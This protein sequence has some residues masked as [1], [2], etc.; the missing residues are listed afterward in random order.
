MIRKGEDADYF[1]MVNSGKFDVFL[2]EGTEGKAHRTYTAG[3][4]F[5]EL[6]LLYNAPRAA[7]VKCSEN[8]T[9]WVLDRKAFRY[10]MVRTGYRELM[11]KTDNFLKTC[12]LLSPLTDA[13]RTKLAALMEEVTLQ[14]GEYV[15]KMGDEAASLYFVKKG[16]VVCHKHDGKPRPEDLRLKTGAVF[17]ESCLEPGADDAVRKANVVA[18]GEVQLLKLS[19]A[20][21]KE[22]L[23]TLADVVARNFMAKVLESV[24]IDDTPIFAQL[25]PIELEAFM[26][27]LTERSYGDGENLIEEGTQQDT[28]FIVKSGHAHVYHDEDGAKKK[29]A[30]R[31]EGQFFGER[32]LLTSEPAAATITA[33]SEALRVYCCDRDAF[34]TAIGPVKDLIT[35]EAEKRQKALRRTKEAPQ[36]ADLEHRRIVGVGTYGRVRLCL[37][38]VTGETYALKMMRKHQVV[39]TKQQAHVISEKK[40]LATCDHPFIMRLHATYHDE[41]ELYMLLELVQG[42]E[43]YSMLK[44]Q[45]PLDETKVVF[46]V[47]QVTSIISYLHTLDI[48]YRDLKPENLLLDADGYLKLVDFGFAKVLTDRTWTL[49]GTPEYLAPE[50]ILVKGHGFGVDWW[51]VGILA[52]ECLTGKTPFATDDPI[53]LYRK[54]L[55][56]HIP[57]PKNMSANARDAINRLV[58]VDPAKRLGCLKA[59]SDEVRT[60]PF[61]ASIEWDKLEERAITPPYKPT[62][63]NELDDSNFH[64]HFD[65]EAA[66]FYP[67]S[68]FPKQMF[69]EFAQTWVGQP[70]A[71]RSKSDLGK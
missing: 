11:D 3:E 63:K 47:A 7:T 20:A 35:R 56:C 9:L 60:H 12:S 49:C 42:G 18:V 55:K 15:I 71:G 21:F 27:K 13:Q 66:K 8:G 52:F 31:V 6:A 57:W 51:T 45:A 44:R 39:V 33:A 34:T 59:G 68:N 58:R 10:V 41:G 62:I 43:L 64:S 14:D 1:Y 17:G 30:T 28:F 25:S 67:K 32:A 38:K 40:I 5:G 4:S 50:V 70:P 22:N 69:A 23:G 46:Y 37:N 19:A 65:D 24:V 16:E 48:V 53:E 61:L 26:G 29:V 2:T 36:W 54:I